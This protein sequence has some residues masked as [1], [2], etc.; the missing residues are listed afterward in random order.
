MD[1]V[2]HGAALLLQLRVNRC[3]GRFLCNLIQGLFHVC[4]HR[5]QP[6]Q[7]ILLILLQR[8]TAAKDWVP[9]DVHRNVQT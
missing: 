8:C 3:S 9:L 6:G 4:G 1:G 2:Q 5:L 7:Q